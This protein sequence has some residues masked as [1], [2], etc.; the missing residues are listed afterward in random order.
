MIDHPSKQTEFLIP[1][2]KM[3]R[4]QRRKAE[5]EGRLPAGARPQSRPEQR[6]GPPRPPPKV[7]HVQ[8][9]YPEFGWR[10]ELRELVRQRDELRR[11]EDAIAA[12]AL[13]AGCTFSELARALGRSRQSVHKRYR[14]LRPMVDR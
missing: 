1:A 6:K 3:S 8:P 11:R 10:Q 2:S 5:R 13:A 12:Q 7:E 9:G 4:Q 14:H